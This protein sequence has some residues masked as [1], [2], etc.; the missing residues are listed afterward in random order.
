M[1][2]MNKKAFC[3]IFVL[4]FVLILS[5]TACQT[6]GEKNGK[7]TPT[8][9]EEA[10]RTPT[11]TPKPTAT[12]AP[13]PRPLSEEQKGIPQEESEEIFKDEFKDNQ[14]SAEAVTR[15]TTEV[16]SIID[17]KLY[18]SHDGVDFV[19]NW[20]TY[21]PDY[22]LT[23]GETHSQYEFFIDLQT[24]FNNSNQWMSCFLGARVQQN[25]G[26][27]GIATDP[28]AGF[29]VAICKDRATVYPGSTGQWHQGLA[30]ITLPESAETMH[31]Y[32]IVDDGQCLYYY[33]VLSSGERHLL[34]KADVSGEKI[35]ITNADGEKILECDNLIQDNTGGYFKIFNHMGNTIVDKIVIKGYR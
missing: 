35:I 19:D 2:F 22:Y 17:E 23:V 15:G 6:G 3:V 13:S 11:P 34:L 10:E 25:S 31:T 18:L 8:P 28:S 21:A 9:T 32:I 7:P 27:G 20:E 24:T 5:L 16:H 1:V 30:Q 4:L 29:W 12:P 14:I 33:M 26:D